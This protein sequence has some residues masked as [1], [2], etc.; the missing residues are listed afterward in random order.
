M[1]SDKRPLQTKLSGWISIPAR[2]CMSDRPLH[3][4]SPRCSS[5][6]FCFI[7]QRFVVVVFN[8]ASFLIFCSSFQQLTKRKLDRS[9]G[10]GLTKCNPLLQVGIGHI[11]NNPIQRRNTVTIST[12]K[13]AG[14]WC[15]HMMPPSYFCLP[16]HTCLPRT[17]PAYR[18]IQYNSTWTKH[19]LVR[20][21]SKRKSHKI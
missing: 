12:E 15:L 9:D 4:A 14:A 20:N 16:P 17:G 10:R 5:A 6:L 18:C 21:V 3:K 2:P 7:W 13:S 11:A 19:T 8:K 1:Q